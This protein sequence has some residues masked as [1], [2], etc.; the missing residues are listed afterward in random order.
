MAVDP[1]PEYFSTSLASEMGITIEEVFHHHAHAVSL[2]FQ[3]SISGPAI[4]AVFDG[5]GYGTDGTI[6]GGEFLI[7]DARDFTR[8]GHMKLFALPGG[9]AAIREPVRI[10]AA[11]LGENGQFPEEFLPLM[12]EHESRVE[13]WLEA[14]K[15]N[16]NSPLTSS[17]G[18]LFDAAAAA[19]GFR[20]QVTFEGQAAMWLEAIADK[21]ETGEYE[22]PFS[23]G[24]SLIIDSSA[25]ILATARDI[26]NGAAPEHVAARFHNS[27]ARLITRALVKLSNRTGIETV[28][29]T[30]G[31]FQ[32]QATR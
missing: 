10:L 4:F 22:V 3:H 32:K 23:D 24:D 30:G 21:N 5:T 9:E 18:R 7:A 8:A 16:I 29:L 11:L 13:L 26:L 20:R 1:H 28:G 17:A 19:V 6:W 12:G 31:C 25:L 27:V 14:A 2:L 15:K